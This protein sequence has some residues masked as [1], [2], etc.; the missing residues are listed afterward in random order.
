MELAG[1]LRVE[2]KVEL[3]FP[4]KLEESFAQGVVA[5]LGAGV[6]FGDVGGVD[7][8]FVG[9]DAVLYVLFVGQSEVFL[10]RDVAEHGAAIPADHGGE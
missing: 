10:G 1:A 4:S 9:D 5:V 3:I 2:A 8:D 6:P 7:G